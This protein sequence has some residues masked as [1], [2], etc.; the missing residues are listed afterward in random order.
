MNSKNGRESIYILHGVAGIGKSTL[1]KSIAERADGMG[2]LGGSFFFS[3]TEEDRK[4]AKS[5]FP[6]LAYQLALYNQEFARRVDRA[7]EDDRRAT[8]RDPDRQFTSLLRKPLQQ[9]LAVGDPILLVIDALDECEESGAQ[10]LL[11]TLARG[12]PQLRRLK[13]FIT[14]RPERHIRTALDKYRNH[15]QFCLQDIEPSVVEVD[16]RRYLDFR[17]SEEEVKRVLP[18]LPPPPWQPTDEQ[19]NA[20]V[21]MSGKLFIIASTAAAFILDDKQ[22]A[23]AKQLDILLVDLSLRDFSGSRHTFLDDM[24]MQIIRAARPEPVGSWVD[25][26]QIIVGTI[27]LLQDPLPCNDL[28]R[29]LSVDPTDVIRTCSHLHSLLA[30]SG[31]DQTFRIHHKSFPDFISDPYRRENSGD[32]YIDRAAHHLRIAKRCLLVMNSNLRH[33]QPRGLYE[34][35]VPFACTQNGMSPHLAYACAYWVSHLALAAEIDV[36]SLFDDEVW[37]LTECFANQYTWTW[38]GV[39][40]SIRGIDPMHLNIDIVGETWVRTVFVTICGDRYWKH[41]PISRN[42]TIISNT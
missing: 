4:T 25:W 37:Q 27:T 6:T 11:D 24:Y 1:A 13:V 15:E 23:P 8:E 40:S 18:E 31:K 16:I 33:L 22:L 10:N 36:G 17:L 35:R 9:V 21:Q 34:D 20:L 38:L 28:A 12:I 41:L 42:R 32:F 2:V 39:L 30:P 5:F 19:K 14:A 29:F 7:L 26:F 3:R